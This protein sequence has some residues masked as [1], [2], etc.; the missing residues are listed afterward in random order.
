MAPSYPTTRPLGTGLSSPD[1]GFD[2][3]LIRDL[4]DRKEMQDLSERYRRRKPLGRRFQRHY[5]GLK[6]DLPKKLATRYTKY[7]IGPLL[8]RLGNPGIQFLLGA[9]P[10]PLGQYLPGYDDLPQWG[11]D[12]GAAGFTKCWGT[13][14]NCGDAYTDAF[15]NVAG[16]S[17]LSQAVHE[18]LS[19]QTYST[20]QSANLRAGD[21]IVTSTFVFYLGFRH[22]LT[23]GRAREHEMWRRPNNDPITIPATG[24]KRR[25]L[26]LPLEWEG[27][28]DQVDRGPKPGDDVVQGDSPRRKEALRTVTR[29]SGR[30]DGPTQVR[31]RLREREVK[32]TVDY[33]KWKSFADALGWIGELGDL[34]GAIYKALP[35]D[36]QNWTE[37]RTIQQKLSR[38]YNN[39]GDV[40]VAEAVENIIAN[41][42]EDYVYGK[43]G[44]F[45][46][47]AIQNAA[48][49]GYW[50]RPFGVGTGPAV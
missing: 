27:V 24:I 26:V 46:K 35:W 20:A 34:V 7:A 16:S 30:T 22:D 42:I 5:T 13:T 50:T 31:T 1:V 49:H 9:L 18:C 2:R 39:L 4:A 38:I 47:K 10:N 32:R 28:A 3:D 40:D 15:A 11:Y 6:G 12:W 19:F 17:C 48:N 21:P 43:S 14:P 36:V 25:G 41:Q 8:K 37:D 45:L 23:A 33:A 29:G 44:D